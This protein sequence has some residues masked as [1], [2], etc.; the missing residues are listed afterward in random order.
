MD[1]DSYQQYTSLDAS[2][3]NLDIGVIPNEADKK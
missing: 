2:K 3:Q 1:V